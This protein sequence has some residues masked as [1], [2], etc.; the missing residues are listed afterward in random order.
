MGGGGGVGGGHRAAQPLAAL[1]SD[2]GR[3]AAGDC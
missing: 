1:L 3:L 2:I